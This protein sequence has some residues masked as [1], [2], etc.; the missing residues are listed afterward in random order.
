M[1]YTRLE[2]ATEFYHRL[3]NPHPHPW[4]L[5][6]V[7]ATGQAHSVE[8]FC[9]AAYGEDWKEYVY[10][11]P[12]LYRPSEIDVLCGDATKAYKALDWSPTVSFEELVR[13]MVEAERSTQ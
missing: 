10:I 8:D 7:I 5:D 9:E 11:N 1:T 12:E 6:Y 3:G 13:I 4:M 2:W